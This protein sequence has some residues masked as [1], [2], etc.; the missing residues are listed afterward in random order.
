MRF[1]RF[2]D[3]AREYVIERPD[4]PR[5]WTNYLGSTEYGAI[6]T[7]NA[8]GF[9]FYKSSAQGR[10]TRLVL[11]NVPMDQPGRYLY[12]RDAESGD[13]WSA[14]WQPVGK[15][16]EEYESECRHGTAYTVIT[17]RYSEVRTQTTYFVPLGENFELWHLT[18]KNESQRPRKLRLFS[19]VEFSGEWN[20]QQDLLNLQFTQY[21][22]KAANVDGILQIGVLDNV[23]PDP[24][25]FQNR[26]QGRHSFMALVG[27]EVTGFDTARDTFIGPYRGYGNPTVVERGECTGSLAHGDNACGCVQADL[28]LS[29]GEERSLWVVMGVGTAANEGRRAVA[30]FQ[31]EEAVQAALESLKEHWHSRL[32]RLTVDTPDAEFNSMVNVWNAYN[33]LITYAWSRA[34]SLVYAGARDGLGYR[35]TVQDILGVLPAMAEEAGT[36]LE[37]MITGQ[38]ESGGALPVVKPFAHTPGREIAPDSYRSDDCLWLF[39]TVPAYVKETGD[40]AFYNK[41]LPY[42]D[43]G[44]ATVLGHLRRALEF[45]LAR[46]GRHG[47]PCG[48][49]ADW[50]DCFHLGELGESVF[51]TFQVRYGLKVYQEIAS[52]LDRPEEV[53]WA[54]ERLRHI[55]QLIEEHTWDGQWFVRAYKDDGAVYGSSK[56]AEGR[57]FLNTQSWA[58]LADVGSKTQRELAMSS[59]DEH[60]A[61]PYGAAILDPPYRTEDCRV[62]RAMVLNE[63]Q[64]ENA[65]IF[66]HPQGWAVIA[67]TLLGH[68][69]R[70]YRYYRAYMPAA[71]NE[72]A[73]VRQIE[74]YVHCQSTHSKYSGQF[75]ASRLPWLSGTASWSYFAATQYILGIQPDYDGLRLDPCL[76]SDWK[77]VTCHRHFRGKNFDI[78][79]KNGKQGKGVRRLVVN[80]ELTAGALIP[81]TAFRTHN[82]VEVELY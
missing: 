5:S 71:Y 9:S 17:S 21:T 1:G 70:A 15:A 32:G 4:T 12:L 63:G 72:H 27:A 65:G 50:N 7:N 34:A 18:V 66:C 55:D 41:V 56:N 79:I 57:I 78:A 8:G 54:G 44:E 13:Y 14:S 49:D 2:D 29:P 33:C 37:L 19:Y 35:D 67:N 62:I 73:E 76:P 42:A 58:V 22:V 10:F 26:D 3:E 82:V 75:G 16:L 74:P 36:R 51:V 59:V 69:D 46:C 68:N 30:T 80:G 6:I 52:Y 43:R 38:C 45:N 40:I 48:L 61:T 23:P 20:I 24:N 53:S 31:S 25:N 11:N 77:T 64:K 81:A 60:L 28:S 39:N 47:L